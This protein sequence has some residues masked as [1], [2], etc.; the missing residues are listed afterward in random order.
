[1]AGSFLK[2]HSALTISFKFTTFYVIHAGVK[3]CVFTLLEY[4]N[5]YLIKPMV[6]AYPIRQEYFYLAL[7]VEENGFYRRKSIKEFSSKYMARVKVI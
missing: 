7:Y 1:M 2:I 5:L 3:T 4:F 6:R